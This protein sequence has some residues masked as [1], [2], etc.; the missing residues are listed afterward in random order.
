MV[1]DMRWK[2]GNVRSEMEE[3]TKYRT[4]N[5]AQLGAW[6]HIEK[7]KNNTKHFLNLEKLN[8]KQW[9]ISRLKTYA[10]ALHFQIRKSF[11]D[12]IYSSRIFQPSLNW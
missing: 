8:F 9:K 7:E 2:L 10:T 4:K 12:A 6:L 3:I 5:A 11:R 1:G